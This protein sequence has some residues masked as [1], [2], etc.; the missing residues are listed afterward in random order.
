MSMSRTA[1]TR[2]AAPRDL[3]S[4]R[5]RWCGYLVV[6]CAALWLLRG[7]A[8]TIGTTVLAA[9]IWLAVWRLARPISYARCVSVPA[10]G[11]WW[12]RRVRGSWAQ[13]AR[14]CELAYEQPPRIRRCRAEWPRIVLVV[15]PLIGQTL[16]E[17]ERAAEP[18]RTAYGASQIRI[19]PV[20]VRDVAITLTIGDALSAP[21]DA[22][23]PEQVADLGRVSMGRRSDG[24]RWLLPVGPH[25]LVAGSSGAGKG[26][27]FWSFVFAIAPAVREGRVQLHGVDL[28]GG[29]EILMGEGLFTSQATSAT[30]AV[31]VLEQLVEYG[32]PSS[33]RPCWS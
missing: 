9:G 1:T 7:W 12:R 14:C 13:V 27:V 21:F 20:N 16:E 29:M 2:L 11:A 6:A 32:P 19:D 24:E 33:A 31:A 15:R 30:E 28:K 4:P 25:T 23:V 8:T 10:H 17:F 18:V 3:S 26:S 22:R 5:G